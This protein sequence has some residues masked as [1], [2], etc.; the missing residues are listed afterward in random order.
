MHRKVWDEIT[1]PFPNFN[2][3]TVEFWEW[4]SNFISHFIMDV[5]TYA[6]W[7]YSQSMSVKGVPGSSGDLLKS[8]PQWCFTDTG[9]IKLLPQYDYEWR[10]PEGWSYVHT[11]VE[12]LRSGDGRILTL[13]FRYRGY[14]HTYA[15]RTRA[16]LPFLEDNDGLERAVSKRTRKIGCWTHFLRSGFCLMICVEA[17]FPP[18]SA[19]ECVNVHLG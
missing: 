3:C 5:I 6:C 11:C 14:I 10:N 7:D 18:A 8:V 4:R 19:R 2:G 9:A 15:E 13:P 17:N 16:D 12:R 1:S